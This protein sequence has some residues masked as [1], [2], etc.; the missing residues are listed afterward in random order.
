MSS[1]VIPSV[2]PKILANIEE[3]QNLR[4]WIANSY[5]QIEFVLG[6]LILRCRAFP[7]Y[8]EEAASRFSDG[9]ADLVKKIRRMLNKSGPLSPYAADL[10]SIIERFEKGHETRNLLAHGFCEYIYTPTGDAGFRFQKWHRQPDRDNARLIRQFRLSDLR[11][12][13]DA[14]VN[15]S[16]DAMALFIRIHADFGWIA[17]NDKPPP[18]LVSHS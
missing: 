6:D 5:A 16:Q 12:E 13:K 7:E 14:F 17:L 4:G 10:I 3:G 15:L 1:D 18:Q 9:A 2:S 11:A 8:T